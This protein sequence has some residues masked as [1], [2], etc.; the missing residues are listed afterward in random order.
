MAGYVTASVTLSH[1]G[2]VKAHVMRSGH[3]WVEFEEGR[4][5]VALHADSSTLLRKKL[6]DALNAID[7]DEAKR[8]AKAAG[9]PEPTPDPGSGN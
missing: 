8:E 1:E 9:D 3:C 2:D 6:F 5:E 4:A 7:E